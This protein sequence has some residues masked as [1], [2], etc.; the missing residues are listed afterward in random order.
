MSFFVYILANRKTGALYTGM[1]NDLARRSWEHKEKEKKGFT[2]R[3]SIDQLVFYETYE[4]PHEAI[5]R[6]KQI[7]KWKRA[8]KINRINE[9]NPDWKDLY[10]TLN[11]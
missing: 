6:E 8:W 5:T 2:A 7:K 10:L 3:Y 11:Q 1:T 4:T 9:I